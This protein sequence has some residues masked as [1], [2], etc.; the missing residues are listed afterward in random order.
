MILSV[1]F[2]TVCVCECLSGFRDGICNFRRLPG[3][4]RAI[5]AA[6]RNGKRGSI[7]K[8]FGKGVGGFRKRKC[9]K[10][11]GRWAVGINI[12]KVIVPAGFIVIK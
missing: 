2:G 9:S 12:N 4:S 3:F 8:K 11:R 5:D 7:I 10:I 1:F 6:E